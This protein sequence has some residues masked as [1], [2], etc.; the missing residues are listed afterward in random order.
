MLS[1]SSGFVPLR[2]IV[3]GSLRPKTRIRSSTHVFQVLIQQ[4]D[5]CGALRGYPSGLRNGLRY[6][7]KL[8]CKFVDG[9]LV[10]GAKGL[11]LF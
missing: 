1:E 2:C 11:E 7:I 8:E 3:E 6:V 5:C 9:R 4:T 10:V